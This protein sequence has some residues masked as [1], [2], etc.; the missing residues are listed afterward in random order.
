MRLVRRLGGPAVGA[1]TPRPR[2]SRRSRPDRRH[3]RLLLSGGVTGGQEAASPA[4][5]GRPPPAARTARRTADTRSRRPHPR[6]AHAHSQADVAA[7][8]ASPRSRLPRRPAWGTGSRTASR[9]CSCTSTQANGWSPATA[10]A[11]H[12]ADPGS[13]A[14]WVVG[15]IGEVDDVDKVER[16][17]VG[18][19]VGGDP[20]AA[21]GTA[22]RRHR[23]VVG[24]ARRSRTH[25]LVLGPAADRRGRPATSRVLGEALRHGSAQRRQE[26]RQ[27]QE[28]CWSGPAAVMGIEPA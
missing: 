24:R 20:G 27:Q 12:A 19:A 17:D 3:G 4:A 10:R 23:H 22:A 8:R 11:A 2:S 6:A 7:P 1:G 28:T 26:P 21:A 18:A 16:A 14:P 9:A 13:R 15:D 25:R 5:S